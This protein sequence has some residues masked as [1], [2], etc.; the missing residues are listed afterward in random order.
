MR[1]NRKE[2]AEERIHMEPDMIDGQ[3][4]WMLMQHLRRS[5]R[6]RVSEPAPTSPLTKNIENLRAIPKKKVRGGD[7]RKVF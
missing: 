2:R 7:D 4:L 5:A 1:R 3:M 6:R